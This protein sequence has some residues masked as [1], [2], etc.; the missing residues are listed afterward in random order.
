MVPS[1][2]WVMFG[3]KK[4]RVDGF[5]QLARNRVHVQEGWHE[6]NP[7]L[8]AIVAATV[9]PIFVK[10]GNFRW[11]MLN[12]AYC[13]FVGRP[14]EALI[15]YTDFELFPKKEATLFRQKDL[16]VLKTGRENAYESKMTDAAG[17]VHYISVKKN[18]F[19]DPQS[20]KKYI[21]GIIRDITRNK[22]LEHELARHR[23]RLTDMISERTSELMATNEHLVR[24][25]EERRKAE[26]ERKEIE[27]QLRRARQ[28]EAIG[29]L[30]GGV[31][32]DLNNILSGIVSY[33][34]LILMDMPEDNPLREPIAI[35]QRSGKKAA[36]IVQDLLTLSRR[37]VA[38]NDP[39][40]LNPLVREY[41][42]SPEYA[43][44]IKDKPSV[45]V[46]TALATE[47]PMIK[48]SALHLSKTIM[49]LTSNAVEAIAGSGRVTISTLQTTID[50]PLS[51][52]ESIP[53][54][55]HV[56]L[57]VSDSGSGI[58]ARDLERIFEPFFT[59]KKLGR[60]GT[61]LGMAVVWGAVKDH[62]GYIDVEST[63]GKG[64]IFSLYFPAG[65]SAPDQNGA[66]T[67]R[68]SYL[69][70]GESILIVDDVA[71]QREIASA[72]LRELGYR[73]QAVDGGEA[74]VDII[75]EQPFDL[76]LLD[77]IM[78]PGIDGYDTYRRVA[79]IYPGQRAIV[80]SGFSES[81]RVQ[82]LKA[83]GVTT[84][85]RKPYTMR[86]LGLAIRA[87]FARK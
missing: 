40:S 83:L 72:M 26:R 1:K 84:Y 66:S 76:I 49:N 31:A 14:R 28:M 3:F 21:V 32:H 15:G 77:M 82:K 25:I 4:K 29:T 19:E 10:D 50:R 55:R 68:P 9:D 81:A 80:T 54:G 63:P 62:N 39:V 46:E 43:N 60:S 5:N 18:L 58:N 67:D 45:V 73:V 70:D 87:E 71:D 79:D 48:G 6:A 24:E 44:L 65:L 53:A 23:D 52:Y 59:R 16:D 51:A 38:V 36:A 17:N 69:G 41:L 30:A 20:H 61:G 37:A 78:D 35:M 42:D 11:V 33:P 27:T 64:S 2:D 85:L 56:V 8:D 57:R 75:R 74:A 7:L 12:D 86:Q 13:R 47:L 34:D 22:Q